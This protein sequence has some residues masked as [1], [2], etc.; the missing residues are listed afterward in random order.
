MAVI[1]SGITKHAGLSVYDQGMLNKGL[2]SLQLLLNGPVALRSASEVMTTDYAGLPMSCN[3]INIIHKLAE[4][5]QEV[6]PVTEKG[7][8]YRGIA[9]TR[10]VGTVNRDDMYASVKCIFAAHNS[11]DKLK[12]LLPYDFAKDARDIQ[13]A[14]VSE[15]KRQKR[16]RLHR[17]LVKLSDKPVEY[18]FN[19]YINPS[20]FPAEV[21]EATSAASNPL[22]DHG[23]Y[24]SLDEDKH[25]AEVES[26]DRDSKIIIDDGLLTHSADGSVRSRAQSVLDSLNKR[27]DMLSIGKDKLPVDFVTT[28]VA[29]RAT[30]IEILPLKLHQEIEVYFSFEE[31][32]LDYNVPI[33][34]Y[35]FSVNEITPMEHIYVLFEMVK[36]S[37]IFVVTGG[38]LMGMI[39]RVG[40]LSKLQ[41]SAAFNKAEKIR[42]AQAFQA[43][44]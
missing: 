11:I 40:L 20:N 7:T 27:L 18:L 31:D 38:S 24:S 14:V 37:C 6:F 34:S 44:K 3:M 43:G 21:E 23:K 22:H 4:T 25:I 42:Q 35:P 12:A 36:V 2:E 1:A 33:N 16:L 39:T 9:Q 19:D 17:Y 13:A 5:P 32:G 26:A 15:M 41:Q 10:L 29:D 28:P 30:I 8:D